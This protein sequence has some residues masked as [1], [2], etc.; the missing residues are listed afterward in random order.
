MLAS[1]ISKF[2]K[3]RAGDKFQEKKREN[4]QLGILFDD[5]GES[6]GTGSSN[7]E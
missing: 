6:S 4:A 3:A 1:V 5:V 2:V 7:E